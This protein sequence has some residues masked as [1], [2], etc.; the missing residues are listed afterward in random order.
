MQYCALKNTCNKS[1][2]VH[3]NQKYTNCQAY[4]MFIKSK[5]QKVSK[6]YNKD[7]KQE[8]EYLLLVLRALNG[9]NGEIYTPNNKQ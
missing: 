1:K 4:S 8:L 2:I 5:R 9:Q 6:P 7:T 3:Y